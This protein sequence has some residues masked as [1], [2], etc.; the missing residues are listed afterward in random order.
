MKNCKNKKLN[1]NIFREKTFGD[2]EKNGG[3][4][5]SDCG[6]ACSSLALP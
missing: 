3:C 1:R 6:S 5:S 2:E 4:S